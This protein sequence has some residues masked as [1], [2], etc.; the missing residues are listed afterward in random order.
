MP[1]EELKRCRPPYGYVGRRGHDAQAGRQG[2]VSQIES[3]AFVSRKNG[4]DLIEG[5]YRHSH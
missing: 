3:G 5:R 4:I 2:L 1:F